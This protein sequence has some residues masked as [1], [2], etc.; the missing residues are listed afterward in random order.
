MLWSRVSPSGFLVL[1]EVVSVPS[2]I[3]LDYPSEIKVNELP[4]TLFYLKYRKNQGKGLNIKSKAHSV[5]FAVA[6]TEPT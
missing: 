3:I 6:L 4:P 1:E 5:T 2:L